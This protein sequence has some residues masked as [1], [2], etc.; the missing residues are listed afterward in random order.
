MEF[1]RGISV[2]LA[3]VANVSRLDLESSL[4]TRCNSMGTA[5]EG[6]ASAKNQETSKAAFLLTV[7]EMLAFENHVAPTAILNLR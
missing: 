5:T 6:G 1:A 7:C 4:L 2:I 3:P